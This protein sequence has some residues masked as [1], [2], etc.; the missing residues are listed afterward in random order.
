M[1]PEQQLTKNF[2]AREY[3][4]KCGCGIWHVEPLLIEMVQELRDAYGEPL[5]IN[6]ASRCPRHNRS[7]RG[8]L[9][10]MHLTT[11]RRPCRAVDIHCP[12]SVMRFK[13]LRAGLEIG[14][15]GVGIADSYIHLD[16]RENTKL[17]FLY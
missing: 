16:V 8:E 7:I 4:C 13:L 9:D 2:K 5:Q 6:S 14:F 1:N 17:V 11:E 10:S 12:N 15:S 3:M